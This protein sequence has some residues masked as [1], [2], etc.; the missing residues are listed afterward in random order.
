M[1]N[2]ILKNNAV[3]NLEHLISEGY[4]QQE[5]GD[6]GGISRV[7]VNRILRG[8]SKPEIDTCEAIAVSLGLEPIAL[9]L[10]PDEFKKRVRCKLVTLS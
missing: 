5:L 2:V 4:T 7:Q 6:L 1:D 10:A 8:H 9:L 3:S